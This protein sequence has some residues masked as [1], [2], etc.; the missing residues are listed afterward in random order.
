[1][2]HECGGEIWK[3]NNFMILKGFIRQ[4]DLH[5]FN[6]NISDLTFDNNIF[7]LM[8]ILNVFFFFKYE[9]LVIIWNSYKLSIFHN[10][11]STFHSLYCIMD[12]RHS[13]GP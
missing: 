6:N 4:C 2:A 8:S 3:I 10:T 7:L 13:V 11:Y 12:W 1:M 5:T 9:T